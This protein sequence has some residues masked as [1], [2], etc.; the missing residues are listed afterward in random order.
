MM[1]M[2]TA[3]EVAMARRMLVKEQ[4]RQRCEDG[5][6]RGKEAKPQRAKKMRKTRVDRT[7]ARYA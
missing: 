4:E 3:I 5:Q 2:A 7:R 6:D 1:V